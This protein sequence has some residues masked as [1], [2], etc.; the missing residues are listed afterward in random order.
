MLVS[1]RSATMRRPASPA[2]VAGARD[3]LTDFLRQQL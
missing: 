3:P 2:G 1:S